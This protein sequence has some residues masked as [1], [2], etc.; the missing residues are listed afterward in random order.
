MAS[1]AVAQ[2]TNT[3]VVVLSIIDHVHVERA[4]VARGIAV[5]FILVLFSCELTSSQICL[6]DTFMD[7]LMPDIMVFS[8]CLYL[9][10]YCRLEDPAW[11]CLSVVRGSQHFW[12]WM[13]SDLSLGSLPFC[14]PSTGCAPASVDSRN[15][16]WWGSIIQ[17]CSL[18]VG[19]KAP[20]QNPPR[21]KSLSKTGHCWSPCCH[22]TPFVEL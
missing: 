11:K 7:C 8:L 3:W 18:Y 5:C 2:Q 12:C 14:P 1:S 9:G 15:R 16:F 6:S 10:R 4:L 19:T 17:D 13:P 21:E 20:W 22:W